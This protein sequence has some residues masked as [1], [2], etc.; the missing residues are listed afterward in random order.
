MVVAVG[1][2]RLDL[3]LVALSF[4]LAVTFAFTLSIALSVALA[5]TVVITLTGFFA[6]ANILH[7][8]II[9]AAR[10]V[11][12]TSVTTAVFVAVTTGRQLAS[13]AT[14][15]GARAA[16]TGRAAAALTRTITHLAASASIEAPAGRRRRACPLHLVSNARENCANRLVLFHT[17]IF[18]RSSRPIRLLCISW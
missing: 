13:R 12:I 3:T 14:R 15:W 18:R 11:A 5:L 17:S 7:V 4:T 8:A 9:G 16:T 2:V 10:T 1:A 6:I